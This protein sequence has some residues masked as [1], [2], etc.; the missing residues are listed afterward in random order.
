MDRTRWLW[1]VWLGLYGCTGSL[2]QPGPKA[3]TLEADVGDGGTTGFDNPSPPEASDRDAGPQYYVRD[4]GLDPADTRP[5][6]GGPGDAGPVPVAPDSDGDGVSD[7]DELAAGTDP[8]DPDSDG[9]GLTDGDEL[10]AG[11]DPSVA[12]SDGDGFH[13]GLEAALGTDALTGEANGC[14]AEEAGTAETKRPVDIIVIVDNSSS[15]NGE[16][17]AI[18]DRINEDF[19]AILNEAAVDWRLNLLSRHGAIDHDI[20]RCDD[21]GICIQGDLAGGTTSC[22]PNTAPAETDQ[23]KHYSICIDSEDGLAKAAA[24][25]DMSPPAWAGTFE[26]N[27][28]FDAAGT[29][30]P[31]PSA[32]TG[33]HAWLRPEAL[34]TFL[35]IT[36]DRSKH[37]EAG[38]VDWM[39]GKDPSYFGTASDPNW[40]FHSI[41]AVQAKPEPTEPWYSDEPVLDQDCGEGSADIGYDYQDLSIASGGLRFPVCENGNFDAVFRAIAQS[42]VDSSRVPCT[43]VPEAVAGAGQPDYSRTALVYETSAG[44]PMTLTPVASENACADGDYFVDAADRIQ[45]CP[46]ACDAVA[47]AEATRLRLLVACVPVCGNGDLEEGEECDDGNT[48]GG[49]ACSP[50]CT[51]ENL[52]GNG[53]PDPGEECD[54]G[55]LTNGDGCS[56]GCSLE[57]GCGDGTVESGEECDDDNLTA[58]DGCS[59]TCQLEYGCGDGVV[60]AGEDCD[61]DNL[62]SG[63]G[64]SADCRAELL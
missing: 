62:I 11:T 25:F 6:D 19:G 34:R 28:Y 13:D 55:N 9:D 40:V 14:A 43:L 5:D 39:Y 46:T 61:D 24:S 57:Q 33:W 29:P 42:V 45:L 54:D 16:I 60:Q 3:R 47:A 22:D 36:D 8:N 27:V 2:G 31:S 7:A 37:S 18:Q 50:S 51:V 32:P 59:E 41:I 30:I 20:T 38:F 4:G 17:E 10:A 52:C 58:G 64:C 63:D 35:M 15:M 49:D 44:Q 26:Q 23:F 1:V 56:A 48:E 21:N 53:S 12:D